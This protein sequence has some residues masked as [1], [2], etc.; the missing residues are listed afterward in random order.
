MSL[1]TPSVPRHLSQMLLFT[2]RIITE[3]VLDTLYTYTTLDRTYKAVDYSRISKVIRVFPELSIV[4]N[5][6]QV[7]PTLFMDTM[8]THIKI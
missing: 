2:A 5:K 7:S 8:I 3:L 4:S 1:N 6:A